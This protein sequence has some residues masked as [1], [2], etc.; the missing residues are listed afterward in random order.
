MLFEEK[1]VLSSGCS[2]RASCYLE[3]GA[4]GSCLE[5]ALILRRRAPEHIPGF[6]IKKNSDIARS[7][8][9][10]SRGL[11][12]VCLEEVFL[13]TCAFSKEKVHSLSVAPEPLA[14]WKKVRGS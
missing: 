8:L 7:E 1:K 13:V 12:V 11:E 2:P 6:F 14:I 3:Q 5:I 4:R 9:F 10:L